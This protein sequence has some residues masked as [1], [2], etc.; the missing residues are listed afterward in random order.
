[1]MVVV[2]LLFLLQVLKA[3]DSF[4]LGVYGARAR[5]KQILCKSDEVSH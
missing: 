3:G 2:S 4:Y 5:G 1:M